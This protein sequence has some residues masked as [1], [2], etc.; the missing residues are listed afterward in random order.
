[1]DAE[2]LMAS[3]D[4][5]RVGPDVVVFRF[6][7]G[8][9]VMDAVLYGLIGLFVIVA[10]IALSSRVTQGGAVA[11]GAAGLA[12]Y[13]AFL[14]LWRSLARVRDLLH[15][16]SNLLAV[17]REGVARR[18]RGKVRGWSFVEF[19]DLTV[20]G[21]PSRSLST[22]GR[23]AN[24]THSVTLGQADSDLPGGRI[25]SIQLGTPDGALHD[26][27]VDDASFGPMRDIARTIIALASAETA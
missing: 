16:D 10:A 6:V 5:G 13:L 18:L 7:K 25:G 26:E 21:S 11:W 12:A 9:A 24:W 4:H 1:M 2:S 3:I 20:V 14:P 19:S 22:P 27:L 8:R 15:A 17:T 23:L